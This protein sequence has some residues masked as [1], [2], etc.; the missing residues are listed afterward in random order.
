MQKKDYFTELKEEMVRYSFH[1]LSLRETVVIM[2]ETN[3]WIVED[4][5]LYESFCHLQEM[6]EITYQEFAELVEE[7]NALEHNMQIFNISDLLEQFDYIKENIHLESMY[8][9]NM[10]DYMKIIINPSIQADEIGERCSQY[11][12]NDDMYLNQMKLNNDGLKKLKKERR[13]N[14]E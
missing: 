5:N 12:E 4:I 10:V 8:I 2:L 1:F 14:L 11:D 13:D 7:I 3:R 6:I 9:T